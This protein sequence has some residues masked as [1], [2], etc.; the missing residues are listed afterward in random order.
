[1]TLKNSIMDEINKKRRERYNK[2]SEHRERV[3]ESQKR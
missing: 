1:M 2:D 3:D